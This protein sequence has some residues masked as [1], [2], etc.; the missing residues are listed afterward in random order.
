MKVSFE[1]AVAITDLIARYCYYVD[2]GFADEWASLFTEDGEM[3]GLGGDL[4]G[5]QQLRK[6]PIMAV[7]TNNGTSRHQLTNL[8]LDYGVT[9]DEV[10][11]HCS[12]LMTRWDNGGGLI[13]FAEYDSQL[14][15]VDGAWKLKKH[16]VNLMPARTAPL[17]L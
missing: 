11:M 8:V 16:V 3:L 6:L 1:D 2:F 14:V 5:H 17:P 13:N 9:K 4:K 10:R 15:R 7:K 12:G